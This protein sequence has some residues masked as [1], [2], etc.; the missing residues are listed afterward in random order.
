MLEAQL[1]KNNREILKNI[2]IF[3]KSMLKYQCYKHEG[4]NIGGSIK[5][6]I[7]RNLC[8]SMFCIGDCCYDA[9]K[10]R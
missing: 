10:R 6:Y 2:C 9:N 4:G 3:S 5:I 1:T 8:D 7:N